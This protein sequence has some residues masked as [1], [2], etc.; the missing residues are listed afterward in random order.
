MFSGES[1]EI[2]VRV[3]IVLANLLDD[4]LTHIRVVFLDLFGSVCE[5]KGES[6]IGG[7]MSTVERVHLGLLT[8]SADPRAECAPAHHGHATS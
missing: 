4:I 8:P 7:S 2:L 3:R 6:A 1:R 5:V